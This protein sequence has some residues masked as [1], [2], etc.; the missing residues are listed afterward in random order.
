MRIRF[1]K[2]WD[3]VTPTVTVAFKEGDELTV[4]KDIGEAAKSAGAAK[5]APL[6]KDQKGDD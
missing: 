4:A 5:E 3:H 6:L 1:S 2:D